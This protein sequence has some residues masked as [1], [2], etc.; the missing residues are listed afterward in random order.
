[1]RRRALAALVLAASALALRA[2][3]EQA[4]HA[5]SMLAALCAAAALAAA[6]APP[7]A[8]ATA[9]LAAGAA[10]RLLGLWSGDALLGFALTAAAAGAGA[11]AAA[12]AAAPEESARPL[13]GAASG[14]LLAALPSLIRFLGQNSPNPVFLFRGWGDAPWF[15][16]A[17]PAAWLALGAWC[18]CR[19]L[20]GGGTAAGAW[21]GGSVGVLAAA[22]TP[23]VPCEIALAAAGAALALY[24]VWRSRAWTAP[25]SPRSRALAALV[26]LAA[27][28]AAGAPGAL[29][30][31]WTARLDALYPGGVFLAD[32]DDGSAD[33]SAYR[34]SRGER[35]LLR[36][37]VI[38]RDDPAAAGLALLAALGQSPRDADCRIALVDP[39][40]LQSVLAA[41]AFKCRLTV[42]DA[43]A[44][45]AR[46]LDAE[47]GSPWRVEL[48]TAPGGA[49]A[50]LLTLASPWNA[51]A[52]RRQL[53]ARGLARLRS[54]LGA[55]GAAAVILPALF[56]DD[57]NLDE[58]AADLRRAFATVRAA[59]LPGGDGLILAVPGDRMIGGRD[60][61]TN[62]PPLAHTL[63]DPNQASTA[64]DNLR[65]R[66]PPP[67][68]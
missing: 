29:R 60:I 54:R 4:P 8:A 32:A 26:L 30:Q 15:L 22:A 39:P 45:S 35:D 16:L 25:R 11:L 52:R 17:Q 12:A 59:R 10:A 44:A 18:A 9:S 51:A 37:G 38:Q 46:A 28:A 43:D 3:L 21:A 7:A 61:L 56:A 47:F 6:E 55:N 2:G 68:K 5:A 33:W 42:L 23:P 40:G 41:R 67:A 64:L 53:S 14:A 20:R 49:D 50:A 24:S 1:M 34:F 58:V 63:V 62:L 65:W 48:D 31:A 19:A 36:D 13:W 27:V 57:A 66:P